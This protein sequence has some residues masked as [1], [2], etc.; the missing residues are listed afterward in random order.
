MVK[1]TFHGHACFE[2][3]ANGQKVLIDPFLKGNPLAVTEPENLSNIDAL[4]VSHG[5]G[6]HVGDTVEIAQ[7]NSAVVVAPYEL[8]SFF[9]RQGVKTHP[10]H[11]GGAYKF[12]FAW[13]KLVNALHG[14]AFIDENGIL[15]TGNPCGFMIEMDNL[16]L[17]HSGDTGLFGDMRLFK[18]YLLHGRNIDV[19]FIPIGDNFVMGPDDALVAVKWLEPKVVVP[20]HYNTFPVIE[21]NPEEFKKSVEEQTE[22]NCLVINPGESF[23]IT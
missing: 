14:S 19:A 2:I 16:L 4:L 7:N 3:E 10:M 6:D 20:M 17:Y 5:H 9:E 11:I 12:P 18:E 1:I 8:A 22:T 15:S 21:Q 23:K 13:V